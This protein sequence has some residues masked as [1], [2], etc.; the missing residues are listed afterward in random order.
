MSRKNYQGK[1]ILAD[2]ITMGTDTWKTDVNNN[3]L[4][5]G[6]SGAGKT[7]NY[8]RP[9]LKACRNESIIVSDTKGVLFDEF[10]SP[11]EKAGYDVKNIDFTDLSSGCGYNPLDYISYDSATDTY[12]EQDIM[13]IAR[14]LVPD[15]KSNDPYWN[16]AARQYLACLI[17]FVLEAL[18]K[19]E[20]TL[21]YVTKI[22][23]LLGRSELDYLIREV[24]ALK[25][26]STLPGR[27]DA[28]RNFSGSPR[29]DASVKGVLST[30]L[31][32]LRFDGALAL[33]TKPD[34][35]DLSVFGRKKTALFITI[36]DT[37]RSMDKLADALMTQI[38]QILC[39]SADHDY[40]NHCL[41]IP[42]RIY[43]DDFATNLYIPDFDKTISIIRSR[44]IYV[45]VI[46]QSITQLE[47]LYGSAKAK[48]IINNCDTHLYL[49]GHDI[50]T[51]RLISEKAN[52]PV[53]A[54]LSLPLGE[55][56]LFIRGQ[57]PRQIVKRK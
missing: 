41:D 40:E 34:K 57:K 53:S 6:P 52:K 26:E 47:S 45:S 1:H 51:A 22:M 29:T 28:V 55:G 8:V 35:I 30:A 42:V 25:P 33:Y 38:L 20:H 12:S 54:V 2:G 27:Y 49:G 32:P 10:R 17:M 46:L 44:E 36:S 37:D 5:F 4:I 7:R 39:K 18:P 23:S 14:C 11:L 16:N 3:V 21:K 15:D 24:A 31:D 19:E 50:D 9:N 56:F 13:S 43:L 48:T